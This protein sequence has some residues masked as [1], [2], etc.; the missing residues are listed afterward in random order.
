MSPALVK[1]RFVS[2]VTAPT[3]PENVTVP[4]PAFNVRL[5]APS[6]VEEDPNMIVP[7]PVLVLMTTEFVS[8]IGPINETPADPEAPFVVVIVLPSDT[9]PVPVCDT[10][11]FEVT[12]F[13]RASKPEL[14]KT[15]LP[16]PVVTRDPVISKVFPVKEIP[17]TALVVI[18][19]AIVVVPVPAVW[20]K[21]LAVNVEETVTSPALVT[22]TVPS[23]A[24]LPTAPSKA[25]DPD[26]TIKVRP[27]GPSKVD[28]NV[29]LPA[30]APPVTSIVNVPT[31][32]VVGNGNTKLP[33][34]AVIFAAIVV[35]PLMITLFA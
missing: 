10:E 26:P 4:A 9:G 31:A 23:G 7:P 20:V 30:E 24:V 21:E 33:P 15:I 32:T 14:L 16:P 3:T 27:P 29:T 34:G 1:I 8:V 22:V 2:G 25:R 28:S 18:A 17:V 19:P 35:L 11:P 5:F 6:I 12:V 13:A